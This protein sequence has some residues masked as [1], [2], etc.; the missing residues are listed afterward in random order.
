MVTKMTLGLKAVFKE[1]AACLFIH[2]LKH[3]RGHLWT[4]PWRTPACRTRSVEKPAAQGSVGLEML[5]AVLHG[6]TGWLRPGQARG[7]HRGDDS[8]PGPPP[9]SAVGG[10]TSVQKAH[11][12]LAGQTTPSAVSSGSDAAMFLVAAGIG[13]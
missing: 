7:V 11:L 10:P 13:G 8:P 2:Y 4:Q 12:A 6:P 1:Q 9:K 5:R 3:A